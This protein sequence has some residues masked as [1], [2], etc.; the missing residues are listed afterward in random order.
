[1]TDCTLFKLAVTF[2]LHELLHFK[3]LIKA[4][5]PVTSWFPL[6]AGAAANIKEGV[7]SLTWG[8][9]VKLD[10]RLFVCVDSRF[11]FLTSA[12]GQTDVSPTHQTPAARLRAKDSEVP[13]RACTHEASERC[14]PVNVSLLCQTSD[15]HRTGSAKSSSTCGHIDCYRET[16][17]K[18]LCLFTWRSHR[19][20]GH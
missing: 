12:W 18:A 11:D 4:E 2:P 3:I 16:F 15:G 6:I 5:P 8:Q 19:A 20:T 17:C 13:Q 7:T 14:F 1:M 9:C 10:K